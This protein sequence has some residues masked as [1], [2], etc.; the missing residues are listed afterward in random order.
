[1]AVSMKER[2]KA[3]TARKRENG[4]KVYLYLHWERKRRDESVL[5][6]HCYAEF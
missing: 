4:G 1:M 5:M 3:E 2:R 6:A